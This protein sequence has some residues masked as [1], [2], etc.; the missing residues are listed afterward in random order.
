[1]DN[2]NTHIL[3]S[4]YKV[5]PPKEARELA[6]RIEFHYTPKHGS[7]LNMAEMTISI[8]S[9]QCLAAG[10]IHSIFLMRNSPLGQMNATKIVLPLIGNLLPTILALS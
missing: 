4:L 7:W 1:L 10:L 8:L 6:K 2:L 5:F 9:R 3:A